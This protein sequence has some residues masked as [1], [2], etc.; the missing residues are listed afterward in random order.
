MNHWRTVFALLLL[1]TLPGCVAVGAVSAIGAAVSAVGG[2]VINRATNLMESE[3]VSLALDMEQSLAAVQTALQ[4]M[5][6]EVELLE[7]SENNGYVALF[8]NAK[9]D[10][11]ITLQPE[12]DKLTTYLVQVHANNGFSRRE[13]VETA[14]TKE[15]AKQGKK[16]A[17]GAT[18]KFKHY[19]IIRARPDRSA[20]RVGW[21]R[22]GSRLPVTP[23]VKP[24]W[25]KITMPSGTKA[26][27]KGTI[28][29]DTNKQKEQ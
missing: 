17:K 26:F 22:T 27:L 4:E 18:F 15:I 3:K 1:I 23:S 24:G 20:P 11:S 8:G 13:S 2:V 28:Q 7:P 10:G 25:L 29:H 16:Q 9:L 14:V 21:F 12:T 19:N 6:F 5:Q